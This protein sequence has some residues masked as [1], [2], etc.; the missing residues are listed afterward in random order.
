MN[1]LNKI[2]FVILVPA[3]IQSQAQII[4][5]PGQPLSRPI[6]SGEYGKKTVRY[7]VTVNEDTTNQDY[8]INITTIGSSADLKEILKAVST[9][10]TRNN[11][12]RKRQDV[13]ET[14]PFGDYRD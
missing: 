9:K 14:I 2:F 3:V 4:R 8:D 10:V 7:L 11:K 1:I 6:K 12:T 5:A 13:E